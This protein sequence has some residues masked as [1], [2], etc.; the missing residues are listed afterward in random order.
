MPASSKNP[1]VFLDISIGNRTGGR[2]IFE[3]FA[4]VTPRTAENFRGICT[5][6]YGFGR[7]TK[8]KL[9]YEGCSVFRSSKGFMIQSGDLQFNNGDGGESIYG[10][11][12][13]D[14]DFVRRHTQ[15]GVL[16]MAN[17]GRN[18]NTSQFFITLKRAPQL[19]GRHVVFGQVIE[20][21][22]VIRA[23]AKVPTDLDEKPRVPVKIVGCGQVDRKTV[24][25]E[26]A[27]VARQIGNLQQEM[28]GDKVQEA[29][30]GKAILA[31]KPGGA[32]I[33]DAGAPSKSKEEKER[34]ELEEAQAT[35]PP[36]N[37]R[38]RKLFDLRMKMNSCRSSNNKE[39]IE[40]QKRHADPEYAKKKAEARFKEAEKEAD[41]DKD[42]PLARGTKRSASS[43]DRLPEGKNYLNDTVEI[44]E[45][46]AAKKKKGNPDAFGWDVFNQESLLRAHEKRLKDIEFDE[47][48]YN[49]QKQAL[50]E[51]K[52]SHF[53]GFGQVPSEEAK[54]RLQKA[55][56]KSQDKSKAFSRRRAFNPEE[57]CNFVNE[58]NRVFNKKMDRY[59]NAYT[60]EIRQNLERGTAL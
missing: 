3:L 53:D 11:A 54:D 15:A 51:D 4:D 20:G 16:S 50:E 35:A 38:E 52:S 32:K 39:V 9:S 46:K 30:K 5:G 44:A 6:E 21:M 31:G 22:D 26:Q 17:K 12:F 29:T 2:V 60:T 48:A 23:I 14:E 34:E 55:M 13:N 8:K 10:G 57:D 43:G 25:Q 33:D 49:E 40:E 7:N 36:R 59:F 56:D 42:D 47:K 41:P 1:K 28:L 45:R 18:T 19:D 37:E 27:A 58:R 24:N